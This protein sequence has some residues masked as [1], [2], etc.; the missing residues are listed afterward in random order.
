MDAPAVAVN[1]D[2]TSVAVAWMDMRGGNND[3]KIYWTLI[4]GKRRGGEVPLAE[5]PKGIK[6]HPSIAIDAG[7][8][9]AA[10]EDMRTGTS[11][12]HFWSAD[13]RDIALSPENGKVSFPSVACGRVIGV[14]YE[15]NGDA[16][17]TLAP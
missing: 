15:L 6:G 4:D 7:R 17:F 2:G 13:A 12:I 3:R 11:R 9:Y 8:I 14:A 1:S 10:W 16:V 5:D